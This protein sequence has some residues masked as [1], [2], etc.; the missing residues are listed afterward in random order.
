LKPA[1][2][3]EVADAYVD[4]RTKFRAVVR[5]RALYKSRRMQGRLRQMHPC[6]GERLHY[7]LKD[8]EYAAIDAHQAAERRLHELV[9]Q[10]RGSL[11]VH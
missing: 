2:K 3:D 8:Y 7:R 6:D 9:A 11:R 10:S 5:W 4:K 1:D